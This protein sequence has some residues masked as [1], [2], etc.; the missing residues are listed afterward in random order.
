MTLWRGKEPLVLA[1]QSSARQSLLANAGIEFES[2]PAEIDER[3]I[4]AT[5]GLAA[6][7][8]KAGMSPGPIRRWR[9]ERGYSTSPLAGH[10]RPTSYARFRA[11]A[12]N[13]T[14]RLPWRAMGSYS[15]SMFRSRE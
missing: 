10:R 13:F 4:Q 5:S 1:S 14:P 12:M 9:W 6:P 15:L 11:I 8:G 2:D 7:G 3:A